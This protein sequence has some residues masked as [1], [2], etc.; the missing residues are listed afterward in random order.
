MGK[1]SA[2]IGAS[3]YDRS[4]LMNADVGF[5]LRRDCNEYDKGCEKEASMILNN[6]NFASAAKACLI[7]E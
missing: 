6:S 7:R 3:E 4:G 5:A 1:I 2:F